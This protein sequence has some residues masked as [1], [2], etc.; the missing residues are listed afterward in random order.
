[1]PAGLRT[2]IAVL[3]HRLGPYHMARLRKAAEKL[4]LVAVQACRMD[5]TYEWRPVDPD[6]R[7]SVETLFDVGE[8]NDRAPRVVCDVVSRLL[9]RLSPRAVVIPGWSETFALA[10][11][12]WSLRRG[13]PAVVMSDSLP[14]DSGK[15][16][17]WREAIKRRLVRGY[18]SAL[19]AGTPHWE[20]MR[21]LGMPGNRVILGYDV[22]DNE[23]FEAGTK[24]LGVMDETF[25]GA[26]GVPKQNFLVSARFIPEKNLHSLIRSYEC[27]RDTYEQAGSKDAGCA[28]WDL[29]IIG[30]GPLRDSLHQ[31]RAASGC[32]NTIHLAGFRQ[33]DE[34][35]LYY[36]AASCLILPSISETWG[37][38]VNEAMASGLPVIVSN[39]CGCAQ[40]LVQEGVNGFTFDPFNVE[41]LAQLMLRMS[42]MEA[43]EREKMGG[44]S[45]R[46]IADWGPERFAG[47]LK[48]AVDKALEVGPRPIGLV[49]RLVLWAAMRR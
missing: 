44:E 23:Y 12:Q 16:P 31:A 8:P 13:I 2:M 1:M 37:L 46:I 5:R 29:V 9:D 4:P 35:P 39:R 49:D 18:S 33:Y 34:L 14:W 32:E 40:D 45:R 30:D 20:Y 41:A 26:A 43:G 7:F 42:G 48:A 10:A 17:V 28:P 24:T 38:V 22:V 11:L 21:Q 47:G 19:V 6:A 15:R 27:Y 36:R 3:F 25:V